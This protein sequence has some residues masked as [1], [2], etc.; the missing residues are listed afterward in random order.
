MLRLA[1]QLAGY[2]IT[3][4]GISPSAETRMYDEFRKIPGYWERLISDHPV[5]GGL[6]IGGGWARKFT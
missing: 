6:V 1:R 4:N 3:V 2:R 5:D